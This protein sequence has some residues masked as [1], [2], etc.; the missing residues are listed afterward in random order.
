MIEN[1]SEINHEKDQFNKSIKA[2]QDLFE[3]GKKIDNSL[4]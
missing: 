1:F 4:K 3:A 2:V